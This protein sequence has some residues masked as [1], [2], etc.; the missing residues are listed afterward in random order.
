MEAETQG[1]AWSDELGRW[2]EKGFLLVNDGNSEVEILAHT[3]YMRQIR[4]LRTGAVLWVESWKVEK[5]K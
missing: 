4:I 2:F 1:M 5:S 3:S